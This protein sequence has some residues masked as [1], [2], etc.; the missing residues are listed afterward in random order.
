[1]SIIYSLF[2]FIFN[3]TSPD[4]ENYRVL[5][6]NYYPSLT[7]L[8]ILKGDSFF[9]IL[10]N[11]FTF[12]GLRFELIMIIISIFSILIKN[13]I[14]MKLK[15]GSLI[16][17]FYFSSLFWVHEMIQI[18]VALSTTFILLAWWFYKQNKYKLYWFWFAFATLAHNSAI[19]FVI[20][21]FI[22]KFKNKKFLIILL[23]SSLMFIYIYGFPFE[24]IA[25]KVGLQRISRYYTDELFSDQKVGI[26]T[27]LNALAVAQI[28]LIITVGKIYTRDGLLKLFIPAPAL[29][30]TFIVIGLKL[31]VM[32]IR[33]SHLMFLPIMIL[34]SSYISTRSKAE[35]IF[36]VVPVV[37][38]LLYAFPYKHFIL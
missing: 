8:E 7:S 37:I 17:T 2:V 1:M 3:S 29:L 24:L 32:A 25:E 27:V 20:F 35:R 26:F 19:I 18:R 6:N 4:Y 10:S 9:I 16:S 33:P 34:L 22:K 31:P 30:L 11:F 13:I 21:D 14:F 28:V 23:V 5:I 15:N 38:A 12:M 36:I